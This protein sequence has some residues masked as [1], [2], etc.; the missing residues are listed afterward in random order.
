MKKYQFPLQAILTLRAMK[1]E[2]ALE[3]YARNV[4]ECAVRRSKVIAAT[5]RADDLESVLSQKEGVVFSASMRGAYLRALDASRE[6]VVRH[7]KSLD[8]AEKEKEKSLA[9]YLD[10]KRKKEILEHL[11][12]KQMKAHLAEGYRKEEVEIEDLVISRAGITR[13]AS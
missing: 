12:D 13:I 9:E 6:D 4:Q 3:V 2:Q 11:R 5:R 7:Q 10:R 8:E 1:Q